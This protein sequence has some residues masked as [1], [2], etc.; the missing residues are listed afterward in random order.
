MN[1]KL[2]T[3]E[4]ALSSMKREIHNLCTKV[5]DVQKSQDFITKSLEDNRG[6]NT[7]KTIG[8]LN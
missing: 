2:V 4:N 8:D 7:V 5:A 1:K 3:I 6:E